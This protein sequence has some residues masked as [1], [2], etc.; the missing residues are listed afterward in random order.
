MGFALILQLTGVN[1]SRQFDKLTKT[2]TVESMLT[3]MDADGIKHYIDYLLNHSNE[4]GTGVFV[5]FDNASFRWL[6][7]YAAFRTEIHALSSKRVWIIDQLAS[8]VRN[9]A[10]PKSDDWV[11]MV[12]DWLIVCGLFV[13][14]KTSGKSRYRAVCLVFHS[15]PFIN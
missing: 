4:D 14:K 10:I 7:H 13:V 1:G 2:K 12:L 6:I 3:S 15:G 5:I 9:G 11:Q 8:L